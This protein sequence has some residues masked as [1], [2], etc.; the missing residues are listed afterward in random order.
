MNLNPTVVTANY[1]NYAND[2]RS[3]T[4][5]PFSRWLPVFGQGKFFLGAFLSR[6]SRG[7]RSIPTA[8]SKVNRIVAKNR[9]LTGRKLRLP[10]ALPVLWAAALLLPAFAARADVVFT[11]IYSFTGNNDGAFPFAALVQGRDGSLYG[12]TFG[13]GGRLGA[14]TV[15][16][17]TIMPEFQAMKLTHGTLNL[18]WSTEAGGIYQLQASASLNNWTNLGS[19]VTATNGTIGFT[20][21]VTNALQRFYRVSLAP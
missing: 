9:L 15:F 5:P 6:G 2:Q 18:A 20:E 21:A 14:G 1:T 7:S 10:R 17:L 4:R 19:P 12:T 16:R 13:E 3:W 11:N 8:V